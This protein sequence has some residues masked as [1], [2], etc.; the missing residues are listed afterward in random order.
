MEVLRSTVAL[1]IRSMV[2]S[3]RAAGRQR[4]L[5][6]RHAAM[7]GGAVGEL[8]QLRAGPPHTSLGA[9]SGRLDGRLTGTAGDL[10]RCC[11]RIGRVGLHLGLV[12]LVAGE[13]PRGRSSQDQLSFARPLGSL[14]RVRVHDRASPAAAH[15][16]IL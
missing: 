7:A 4:V 6:L 8:A 9:P 12:V 5:L 2:L 13:K 15:W 14:G 10:T 3:A 11:R 1:A 16:R